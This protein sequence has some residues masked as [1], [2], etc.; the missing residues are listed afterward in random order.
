[1]TVYSG[2]REAGL[3]YD[4][5]LTLSDYGVAKSHVSRPEIGVRFPPQRD[6]CATP[7]SGCQESPVG[8]GF[9]CPGFASLE[10]FWAKEVPLCGS[11]FVVHRAAPF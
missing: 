1:M 10:G 3:V 8:I 11:A 6:L 5:T 7:L 2:R 4:I 9:C